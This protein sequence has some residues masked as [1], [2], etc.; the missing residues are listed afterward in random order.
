MTAQENEYL[1]KNAKFLNLKRC[2]AL[3]ST[4]KGVKK[5]LSLYYLMTSTLLLDPHI[6]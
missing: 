2:F 4:E 6:L 1:F 3:S 5:N